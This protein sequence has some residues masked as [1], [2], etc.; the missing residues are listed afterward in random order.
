[1]T[2]NSAWTSAIRFNILLQCYFKGKANRTFR[3]S[4]S[5]SGEPATWNP[6]PAL[7]TWKYVSTPLL[8]LSSTE[9]IM[10]IKSQVS[11]C[12]L[13]YPKGTSPR[14]PKA[15]AQRTRSSQRTSAEERSHFCCEEKKFR[16]A[17]ILMMNSLS[18][19][20][21]QSVWRSGGKLKVRPKCKKHWTLAMYTVN[22]L[23]P[24][25]LFYQS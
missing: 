21:V 5:R 8:P 23:F 3:H 24:N 10:I 22:G 4:A 1:M 2:E 14:V 7:W 13:Q 18:C 19:T 25:L 12:S 9:V 15:R 16:C 11:V 20:I 6:S 17:L